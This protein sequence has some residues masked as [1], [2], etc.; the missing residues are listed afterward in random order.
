MIVTPRLMIAALALVVGSARLSRAADANGAA[1][2]YKEKCQACHMDGNSPLEEMNFADGKW[3]HGSST[4][5]IE[6]VIS[7]GVPGTAMQPFK[8]QLSSEQIKALARYVRAFD[9]SLKPEKGGK[10]N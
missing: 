2:A 8:D 1:D 9:K 4:A 5:Q 6:K 7:E 3:K 10:K